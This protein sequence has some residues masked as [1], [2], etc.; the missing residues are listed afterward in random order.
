VRR[1]RPDE[2]VDVVDGRL[3]HGRQPNHG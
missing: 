1:R 2:G 3:G